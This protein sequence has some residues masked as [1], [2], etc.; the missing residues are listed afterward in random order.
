MRAVVSFLVGLLTMATVVALGIMAHQ[1]T[2]REQLALL[3]AMLQVG[4]G[5]VVTAAARM[6]F[7]LAIL[8]VIPGPL[9]STWHGWNL[10]RRRQKREGRLAN[11]TYYHAHLQGSHQAIHRRLLHE[12]H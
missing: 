12:C 6:G 8:I 4:A 9:A 3:G 5:L 11:L 2:R 10:R 7:V 1:N